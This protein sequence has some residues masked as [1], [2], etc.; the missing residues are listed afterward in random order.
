VVAIFCGNFAAGRISTINGTGEQTRDYVYVGD[1][2][3]ANVLAFE[4]NGVPSGSYKVGTGSETSVNELYELLVE[5]SGKDLGPKHGPAKVGEQL[6]SSVD[7]TL[8]GHLLGWRPGVG[9]A[10]GLKETLRFLVLSEGKRS[11]SE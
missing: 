6:R 4:K 9:L 11:V 10:V 1:V 3:H 7:P 2:A 5:I 8:A